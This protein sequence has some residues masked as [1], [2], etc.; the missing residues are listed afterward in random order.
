MC[1][2]GV[3]GRGAG[4]L[5]VSGWRCLEC[6]EPKRAVVVKECPGCGYAMEKNGGCDYMECPSGGYWCFKCGRAVETEEV[7]RHMDVEHRGVV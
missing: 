3:C 4:G 2:V 7:H 6:E 5:E 1:G